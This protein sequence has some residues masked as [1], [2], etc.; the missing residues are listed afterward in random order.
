MNEFKIGQLQDPVKFKDAVHVAIASVA[1]GQYLKP[2][3]KI[4]LDLHNRAIQASSGLAIG[5]VDPFLNTQVCPGEWFLL[6]LNP[7]TATKLHHHWEHPSFPEVA[8]DQE[9]EA[10]KN[11]IAELEEENDY[12]FDGCRG[13]Y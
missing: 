13:C 2:G 4:M 11:R 10:L 8:H 1:A 7:S 5:I 3:E 9:I 12:E 6:W